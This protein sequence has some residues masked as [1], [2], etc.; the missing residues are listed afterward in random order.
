MTCP[1]DWLEPTTF[2]D[3]DVLSATGLNRILYDI[4]Y[5]QGY[6]FGPIPG[7]S[8]V[9]L[10]NWDIGWANTWYTIWDGYIVHKYDTFHYSASIK[11]DTAGSV[12]IRW[13]VDGTVV[14]SGQAGYDGWVEISGSTDLSG[15]GLSTGS[16]PSVQVQFAWNGTGDPQDI[17]AKVGYLYE[18][19][20]SSGWTTPYDPK[21]GSA[22][23]AN[24]NTWR[25]AL[26]WLCPRIVQI[27][28]GFCVH[29]FEDGRP[30]EKSEQWCGYILHS[31][32]ILHY[33]FAVKIPRAGWAASLYYGGS[34][35]TEQSGDSEEGKWHH[36]EGAWNIPTDPTF[37]WELVQLYTMS[38][39]TSS[40]KV[41][42]RMVFLYEF[43][44][45]PPVSWRSMPLWEEGDIPSA[46]AG[47]K[48]LDVIYD[49]LTTLH[50]HRRDLNFAVRSSA[51]YQSPSPL[52]PRWRKHFYWKFIHR[53]PYL[54]ILG[55]AMILTENNSVRVDATQWA[56]FDL[57]SLAWLHE[58]D[59]YHVEGASC[60][61]ESWSF[62]Y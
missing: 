43:A 37:D 34:L 44:A 22:N 14:A 39:G 1:L 13:V 29:K 18:S 8:G 62:E 57:T 45:S 35:I 3:G 11:C 59:E 60:A 31:G 12:L 40:E 49:N 7:F 42:S 17:H 33:H 30:T 36:I 28:P 10:E 32:C 20:G 50:D 16:R 4:G 38:Q 26:N 24:L 21:S 52:Y 48:P 41:E 53:A 2:V 6:N 61:Y 19:A 56:V 15:L 46:S 47:D 25:D 54:H 58:G 55:S 5:L 51:S 27:N 9:I 23:A